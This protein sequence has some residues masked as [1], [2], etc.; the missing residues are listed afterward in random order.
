[1]FSS[2]KLLDVEKVYLFVGLR[3]KIHFSVSVKNTIM[4]V[5]CVITVLNNLI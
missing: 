1:V 5:S 3:R 4:L 2:Y